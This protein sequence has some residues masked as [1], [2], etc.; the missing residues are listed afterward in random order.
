MQ[1]RYDF[2]YYYQLSLDL[3]SK[4]HRAEAKVAARDEHI[5]KLGEQWKLVHADMLAVIKRY[6]ELVKHHNAL[7]AYIHS[8]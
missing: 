8:H 6:D 7:K 3:R 5:R 1:G 2:A 4:L